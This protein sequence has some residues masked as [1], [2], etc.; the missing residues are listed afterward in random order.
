ML[1][2]FSIFRTILLWFF[3]IPATI[4][5]F[6]F[7]L[8]GALIDRSGNTAHSA[9]ALWTRAILFLS[10]VKVS[11]KG[12][13]NIPDGPV[14]FVANHIGSFDIPVVQGCIP[15]QFR[16]VAKKSLFKIP[17]VGWGMTLTGHIAV[18]QKNIRAAVGSI[19][20]AAEKIKAGT[21]VLIFPEGSRNTTDKLLPF[22]R[23]GFMLATKS[24][25]P[26]IPVSITGTRDI[27]K[28]GGYVVRPNNAT[29]VIGKPI[30]S[31]GRKVD[32]LMELSREAI[33][34]GISIGGVS[35]E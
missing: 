8:F 12:S 7:A 13:E 3:G 16:W 19:K 1:L 22:K 26:I 30:A 21:S 6:T 35:N 4:M 33:E 15:K 32:E 11:V 20:I 5:A 23:G 28:I 27:I 25:V 18:D 29:L 34:E 17:I 14:V 2:S 10:G 9:G 24:E 31:K